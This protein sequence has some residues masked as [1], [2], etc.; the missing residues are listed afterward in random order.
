[1]HFCIVPK[2]LNLWLG[3]NDLDLREIFGNNLKQYRKVF[4]MTRDELAEKAGLSVDMIG[5]I[6]RG[7][8]AP[9]FDSITSLSAALDVPP[10]A[11]FGAGTITVPGGKRGTALNEINF[12]LTSLNDDNLSKYPAI[13]KAIKELD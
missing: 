9:S 4:K 1:M 8:A 10:A 5:R 3:R 7:Q 11:F 12:E 2:P 13:I 6:E